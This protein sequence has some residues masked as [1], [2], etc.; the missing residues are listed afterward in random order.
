MN[1]EKTDARL[2]VIVERN[3]RFAQARVRWAERQVK[4]AEAPYRR[5]IKK[6]A[7]AYAELQT[8][9]GK[10]AP[11]QRQRLKDAYTELRREEK[12]G[13][14]ALAAIEARAAR[15]AVTKGA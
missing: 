1:D 6:A 8:L 5:R 14:Q 9:L 7:R 10:A 12:A 13:H 4:I 3:L 11:E 2:K 15:R